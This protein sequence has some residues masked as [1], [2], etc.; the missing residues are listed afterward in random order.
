MLRRKDT[1]RFTVDISWR[2]N[3][4]LD[5]RPF[6]WS[7][8]VW[9]ASGA[10]DKMA[11]QL[12]RLLIEHFEPAY[13]HCSTSNEHRSK[14]FVVYQDGA[15]QAERYLGLDV[16]ERLPGVYWVTYFGPWAITKIGRTRFDDL[17]A[18]K[19]ERIG[20]GYL[21]HAYTSAKEGGSAGAREVEGRVLQH[22][23]RDL[24]FDKRLID[25]DTLKSDPKE[26][27]LV[28]TTI[29]ALKAKKIGVTEVHI[30]SEKGWLMA[31]LESFEWDV[32]ELGPVYLSFSNRK[33]I[34]RY[35]GYSNVKGRLVAVLM[36]TSK[37]GMSLQH[38]KEAIDRRTPTEGVSLHRCVE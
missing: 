4:G 7:C 3:K 22:L 28:Q 36:I 11:V 21:V 20:E 30:I 25:I 12:L 37:T 23:G 31:H 29:E 32:R 24:F 26:S 33:I 27:A 6:P 16:G 14:H 5:Q 2:Q 15:A 35:S 1:P 34:M 19:V 18:D 13:G 9:L 17:P 38:I 8:T 10:G